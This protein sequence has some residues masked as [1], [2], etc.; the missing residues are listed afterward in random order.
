MKVTLQLLAIVFSLS[1]LTGCLYP[2]E[3]L[4][5]N[6]IPYEDQIASVQR[7]V[8]QFK[9]DTGGLLPI[10]NRDMETPIY[11]KYPIDFTRISPKY[12]AEPPG[13]AYETGGV[14]LYVL[15][16]VETNPTVKLLDVRISEEISELNLRVQMYRSSNGYAP[17]KEQLHPHVFTLDYSKLGLKEEPY[18]VSPFT[19]KNLPLL[20]TSTNEIVVD[21]RMDL[22][23]YL[24][25][26]EHTYQTGDEIRD[27]LVDNSMFV[28]TNS[29]PYTIN[30]KNEPIFLDN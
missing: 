24:T 21:Y 16:N 19:G 15:V 1:L 28:P 8:D 6:Q 14:Y 27:L 30:D 25:K 17:F 10:K 12:I 5:Q 18:V 29:V 9:E 2:K 11:Q 4:A 20:I 23:E 7:A 22:Y 3:K 26:Y 13:N